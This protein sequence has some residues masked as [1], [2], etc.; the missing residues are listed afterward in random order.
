MDSA[1]PS[2]PGRFVRVEVVDLLGLTVGEAAKA[3]GVTRQALSSLLNGHVSLTPE[4]GIRFEKAFGMPLETLLKMQLDY[5]IAQARARE[6]SIHV[7]RYV[8]RER[9][10]AQHVML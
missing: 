3:L 10:L 8:A 6:D 1:Q 5:D 7:N 4:M 9:P 2:H